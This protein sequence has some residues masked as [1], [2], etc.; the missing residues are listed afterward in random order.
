MLHTVWQRAEY[1]SKKYRNRYKKILS[2]PDW[3]LDD[4]E[5]M[6]YGMRQAIERGQ[7]DKDE[8]LLRIEN[9]DNRARLFQDI[10]NVWDEIELEG[11]LWA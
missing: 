4:L 6:G 11:D 3:G 9:C 2:L 7:K 8:T 5:G 1:L 10:S